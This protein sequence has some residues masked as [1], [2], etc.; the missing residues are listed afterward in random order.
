[1]FFMPFP[2]SQRQDGDA[3][4]LAPAASPAPV[5]ISL[6]KEHPETQGEIGRPGRSE[7]LP[8][9]DREIKCDLLAQIKMPKTCGDLFILPGKLDSQS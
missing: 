2:R 1:M 4:L 8:A 9:T 6:H 3:A 7:Y 5:L